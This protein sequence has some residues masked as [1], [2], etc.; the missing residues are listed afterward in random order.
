ME[1]T[2]SVA[3]RMRLRKVILGAIAN[4]TNAHGMQL[5]T[6]SNVKSLEKRITGAVW[7]ALTTGQLEGT[8]EEASSNH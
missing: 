4:Y 7:S 1:V 2:P 6:P 3:N 8:D 5:T